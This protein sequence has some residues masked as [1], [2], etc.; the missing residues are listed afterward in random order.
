MR[1]LQSTPFSV[2]LGSKSYKD[3]YDATF[4]HKVRVTVFAHDMEFSVEARSNDSVRDVCSA[5]LPLPVLKRPFDDA[6]WMIRDG[7][8]KVLDNGDLV[9]DRVRLWLSRRPGAGG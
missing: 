3:N 7:A 8:G 2:A 5:A 6:E 9:G 4:G 1:Y